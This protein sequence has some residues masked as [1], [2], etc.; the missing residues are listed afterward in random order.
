MTMAIRLRVPAIATGAK[1]IDLIRTPPR[2][3]RIAAASRSRTCLFNG[4][5]GVCK[6]QA[7]VQ[8]LQEVRSCRI[9]KAASGLL[10]VPCPRNSRLSQRISYR[11]AV[12]STSAFVIAAAILPSEVLNPRLLAFRS[13]SSPALG[14]PALHCDHRN[15]TSC[16]MQ[17]GPSFLA[18]RLE[19]SRGHSL[20]QDCPG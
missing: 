13:S 5:A 20:D 17:A 14:R 3:Q 10:L 11:L 4:R 18:L 19:R 7:G 12:D 2:D 6:V 8:E 16:L 15:R 1:S 9:E